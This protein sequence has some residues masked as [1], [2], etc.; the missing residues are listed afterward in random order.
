MRVKVL[1]RYKDKHNDLLHEIGQEIEITK[2]RFE[3]INSTS[4]GVFVQEIQKEKVEA[5]L[6]VRKKKSTQK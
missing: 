4:L 2:E 5:G 1:K 3:E 6:P